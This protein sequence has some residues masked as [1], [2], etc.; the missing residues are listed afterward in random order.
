MWNWKKNSK[1]ILTEL[2][3]NCDFREM[4]AIMGESQRNN[5][6]VNSPETTSASPTPVRATARV[7]LKVKGDFKGGGPHLDFSGANI[8]SNTGEEH[9]RLFQLFIQGKMFQHQQKSLTCTSRCSPEPALCQVRQQG[10][11]RS[12]CPLSWLAALSQL[13]H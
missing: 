13:L 8:G 9:S 6:E 11:P 3:K 12:C 4:R 10:Q 5:C 2:N 7:T 1:H